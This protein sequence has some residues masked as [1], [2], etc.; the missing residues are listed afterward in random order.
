MNKLFPIVLVL[1]FFSCD[2]NSESSKTNQWKEGWSK[3]RF[4]EAK[5]KSPFNCDD[6]G[7]SPY[8]TIYYGDINCSVLELISECYAEGWAHSVSYIHYQNM[9]SYGNSPEEPVLTKSDVQG[10]KNKTKFMKECYYNN[11]LQSYSALHILS[12]LEREDK[13]IIQNYYNE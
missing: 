12:K 13:E 8:L 6:S 9:L 4:F 1:L 7:E 10:I 3:N 5:E 2:E 11:S